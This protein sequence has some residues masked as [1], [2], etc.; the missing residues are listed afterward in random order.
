MRL[1]SYNSIK[2]HAYTYNT[3]NV[4]FVW[5]LNNF[6]ISNDLIYNDAKKLSILHHLI[7]LWL[8]SKYLCTFV[9]ITLAFLYIFNQLSIAFTRHNPFMN[10]Q[11]INCIAILDK[12]GN[13]LL[14]REYK[15]TNISIIFSKLKSENN[16]LSIVGEDLVVYKNLQDVFLF[17]S[18]DI[19]TNEIFL[20]KALDAFYVALLKVLHSFPDKNSIFSKYDMIVLLVDNFVYEGILMEDDGEKLAESMLKRPFEGT[21]GMKIP[22]GIGSIFAKGS[23]IFKR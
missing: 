6:L 1:Y 22:K 20:Y 16:D 4:E 12:A 19:E 5:D 7:Y 21:E 17:I 11:N 15:P 2:W 23:K 18:S 13:V 8:H 3:Y 14:K 9:N 10:I